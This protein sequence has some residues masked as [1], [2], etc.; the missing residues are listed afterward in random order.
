MLCSFAPLQQSLTLDS[1]ASTVSLG[2]MQ[3]PDKCHDRLRNRVGCW[4][5]SLF[6]ELRS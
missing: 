4:R 6:K 1:K 5:L 3:A 2:V